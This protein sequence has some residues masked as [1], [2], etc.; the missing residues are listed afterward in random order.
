MD[1][2]KELDPK[3][4]RDYI[5]NGIEHA[6]IIVNK[7]IKHLKFS[8][9]RDEYTQLIQNYANLSS[10]AKDCIVIYSQASIEFFN[11]FDKI[12]K[13]VDMIHKFQIEKNKNGEK[14]YAI[15]AGN[16]VEIAATLLPIQ[17]Q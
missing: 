15:N 12:E 13:L 3:D 7:H 4:R 6:H 9:K 1:D 16:V 5:I 17:S 11:N 8:S 2:Y 14:E 10:I